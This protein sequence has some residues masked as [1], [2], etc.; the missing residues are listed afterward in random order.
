MPAPKTILLKGDGLFKERVTG[1]A[2]T[3]GHLV[4]LNS[5]GAVVVHNAANANAYP[6]FALEDEAQGKKISE[7]YASGERITYVI[8]QRG[9][10]IYALVPPSAAAIAVGDI[11]ISNGDGTL[12]K[13]TAPTVSANNVDRVVARALEAVDNSGNPSSPARIIVE[14]L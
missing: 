5:A 7:N 9:A 8:P 11:L 4:T 3:P 1:G 13:D 14:I 2:V 10:E 12:K 6:M